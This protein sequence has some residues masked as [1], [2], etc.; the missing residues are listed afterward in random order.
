[1]GG[2]FFK[3]KALGTRLQANHFCSFFGY[4]D[5]NTWYIITS[6]LKNKQ[7]FS[8]GN[9]NHIN[10]NPKRS[11]DRTILQSTPVT[12]QTL[13]KSRVLCILFCQQKPCLG[14]FVHRNAGKVCSNNL[15]LEVRMSVAWF[16]P[17][18]ITCLRGVIQC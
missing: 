5:T 8:Y 18:P 6:W 9:L 12:E 13:V 14:A 2:P 15:A 1:M 16:V 11:D 7:G 4:K 3:G 17:K 10:V